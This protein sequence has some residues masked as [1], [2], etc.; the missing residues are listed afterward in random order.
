VV[1]QSIIYAAM[2]RPE[3]AAKDAAEVPAQ[4]AAK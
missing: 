2:K 3:A 4:P 1:V